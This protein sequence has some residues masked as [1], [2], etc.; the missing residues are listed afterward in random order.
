MNAVTPGLRKAL[1]YSVLGAFV[2]YV[3]VSLWLLASPSAVL[4]HRK[5]STYYRWLTLPGPFF[6]DER[7]YTPGHFYI[8]YKKQG[9]VWTQFRNPEAEHVQQYRESFFD[10]NSKQQ[11]RVT[12]YMG[13]ALYAVWKRKPESIVHSKAF[14]Q[15]HAHLRREYIPADADS[16]KMLYTRAL[17]NGAMSKHLVLFQC[18]YKSY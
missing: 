1:G 8:A 9:G 7:I 16:V 13:R 3:T 10:Y 15:M 6:K 12:H 5:F 17:T 18:T 14:Q 2:I 4:F 11:S